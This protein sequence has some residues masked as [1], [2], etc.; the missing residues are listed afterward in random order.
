MIRLKNLIAFSAIALS[1]CTPS[2]SMAWGVRG[3]NIVA[4]IAFS[5]LDSISRQRIQ[6]Y[7]G[8]TT[9]YE[10]STWM[11]EM[12]SK[13]E[14]DYMKPWHYV[15]FPEGE[16]YNSTSAP[17]IIN[18][19]DKAID[20]L[21]HKQNLTGIEIKTDIMV[22]FHLIGDMHMPL[23]IGYSKDKGGNDVKVKFLERSSNLHWVWDN[24]IIETKN[25]TIDTCTSYL[26]HMTRQEIEG[27][28]AINVEQWIYQPRALLTNVY[29]FS[30]NTIDQQY[31]D[32]N[33][34]I[35]VRQLVIAGIRLGAV[36][37]KIA[38]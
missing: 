12:R 17:N 8:P 25:I 36:L 18:A 4:A 21:A 10:A 7:L 31:I 37:R 23:H 24:E 9:I 13:P 29:N 20:E 1:V 11:D 5:Q 2:C 22:I 6:Q 38:G 35:I 14:Y 30:D 26:K 15:D 33:K 34:D 3:H 27:F 28:K 19:L 32:R 16:R